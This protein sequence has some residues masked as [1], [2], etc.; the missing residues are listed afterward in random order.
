M[1]NRR[2]LYLIS[3]FS[4]SS[5]ISYTFMPHNRKYN[6]FSGRRN[7]WMSGGSVSNCGVNN[8]LYQDKNA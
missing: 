4:V 7:G 1:F 8:V 2:Y 3:V 6:I 5:D